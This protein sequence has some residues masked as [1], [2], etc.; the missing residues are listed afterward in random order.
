MTTRPVET[1]LKGEILGSNNANRI[2]NL[3]KGGALQD[4]K[5]GSEQRDGSSAKSFLSDTHG[6]F[7]HSLSSLLGTTNQ[8]YLKKLVEK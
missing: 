8:S 2:N 1:L 5:P 4:C 6:D 3:C 7:Y